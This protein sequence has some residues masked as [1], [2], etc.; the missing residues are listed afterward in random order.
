MKKALEESI[1]LDLFD[2]YDNVIQ[3]FRNGGDSEELANK[4]L[5]WLFHA[6][7][8]F[9]MM[10]LREAIAVEEGDIGLEDDDLIPGDE[11]VELCGSL[12]RYDTASDL[13][14]FSHERVQDFLRT[15][16]LDRMLDQSVLAKTCLTYLQFTVFQSGP[17]PDEDAL[18]NR[19]KSHPFSLYAARFWADHIKSARVDLQDREMQVN[20]AKLLSLKGCVDSMTQLRMMEIE[21]ESSLGNL[22][23]GKTL[24]HVLAENDFVSWTEALLHG[25]FGTH[26]VSCT[27]RNVPRATMVA[28]VTMGDYTPLHLAA[29]QGH[30]NI[31]KLLL[32]ANAPINTQNKDGVT[33]LQSACYYG[34]TQVVEQ[35]LL[36]GASVAIQA[37]DGSTALH[38]AASKGHVEIIKAILNADAEIDIDARDG[39]GWTPLH[40]AARNGHIEIV[41]FIIDGNFNL[42][43]RSAK[44]FAQV[45]VGG[46]N[47]HGR[48]P[49]HTS[50]AEGHVDIVRELLAA[51]AHVSART[52]SGETALHF[53]AFYGHINVMSV[54]LDFHCD[55][56]EKEEGG[57]TSLHRAAQ[58]GHRE[59]VDILLR[60]DVDV[61]EQ[62]SV[63]KWSALHLASFNGN[64][65]VV[66][67]LL[68]AGADALAEDDDGK[69]AAYVAA[70]NGHLETLSALLTHRPES[71]SMQSS[72]LGQRSPLHVAAMRGHQNI[73]TELLT[74]G[75]DIELQASN[76][77]TALHL[78]SWNGHLDVVDVLLDAKAD[79]N[80]TTTNGS[81]ALLFA[82][83]KGHQSIVVRLLDGHG[84]ILK[85]AKS[86]WTALHAACFAGHVELAY[87]LLQRMPLQEN[88]ST[89]WFKFGKEALQISSDVSKDAEL[90]EIGPSH[91]THTFWTSK[92]KALMT[93]EWEDTARPNPDRDNVRPR[94]ITRS[95]DSAA[96]KL[97][98]MLYV[99]H[100]QSTD[101]IL[102]QFLGNA[103]FDAGLCFHAVR[104]FEEAFDLSPA[105]GEVTQ[106]C[107]M[108]HVNTCD[109]CK[110]SIRGYRYRCVD[111]SDFDLCTT[112]YDTVPRPHDAHDFVKIP[113][114]GFV[115][116][117]MQSK[118]RSVLET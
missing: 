45:D 114:E 59:A 6:K 60:S 61:D 81:T 68:E 83:Q 102:R 32:Q 94:R 51:G 52:S 90:G 8:P 24:L 87:M 58:G 25:R 21:R 95:E 2:V 19:T 43:V 73:V 39:D 15:R 41:Q 29:R 79:V 18:S 107:D 53:A 3:K 36:A 30:S 93:Q 33:P 47:K 96:A 31:V 108:V 14:S 12:V 113:S 5:S 20:V 13:V 23:M 112:C 85:S 80:A 76:G 34:H 10:E 67:Q 100:M 78:A 106:V 55:P 92:A 17:C 16:H 117:V 46:Q 38:D 9:K 56:N 40:Y 118:E 98:L 54:L 49:L 97:A 86:G 116:R 99:N 77:S 91:Q 66:L 27:D 69:T 4:L 44:P 35:L 63:R 65:A 75:V 72:K 50:A 101:H 105:I 1:P 28:A 104:A 42:G 11:L 62:T 115:K 111:C 84:D 110:A 74:R 89:Q 88:P 82:S 7:R 22:H 48:T 37:K 71:I 70:E 26:S 64:G 57:F 109:G 103:Y